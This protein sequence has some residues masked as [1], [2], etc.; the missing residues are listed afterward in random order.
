[1]LPI[2]IAIDEV[3]A[4]GGVKIGNKVYE[5]KLIPYDDKYTP[6]GALAAANRLV[7]EDKVKFIFGSLGSAPLL[8]EQTVT[9][10]EKVIVLTAAATKSALSPT[11][12]YT[13]RILPS[14]TEY[15]GPEVA[16][17][18]KKFSNLKSIVICVPNDET[19]KSQSEDSIAAYNKSGIKILS[20]EFYERGTSDMAPLV[21]RVLRFNPDGVETDGSAPGDAANIYKTLRDMGYKGLL[22]RLGGTEATEAMLKAAGQ[23]ALEGFLYSADADLENPSGKLADFIAEYKKRSPGTL[24]GAAIYGYESFQMLLLAMQKAGTVEDTD[25]V[26]L[27]LEKLEYNGSIGKLRWGGKSTYGIDHQLLGIAYVGQVI[28]GKGKIIGKIEY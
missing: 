15:T 28:E 4:N 27:A 21:S 5:F 23:A 25:A 19:G 10:K 6:D 20:T 7:Y 14:C 16:W 9:E 26:R 24:G 18:A 17:V 1:V 12:L 11:K 22:L 13:F 2:E 3:N 8:A